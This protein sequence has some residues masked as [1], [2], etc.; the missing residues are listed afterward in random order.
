MDN[1]FIYAY[2]LFIITFA[3]IFWTSV[4]FN[5]FQIKGISMKPETVNKIKLY[6]RSLY[7]PKNYHQKKFKAVKQTDYLMKSMESLK[8]EMETQ[9]MACMHY[10]TVIKFSPLIMGPL[11]LINYSFIPY[12]ISVI[13]IVFIVFGFTILPKNYKLIEDNRQYIDQT[14][15]T[16]K[17]LFPE[18]DVR[19]VLLKDY[20]SKY[21]NTIEKQKNAIM[22][23]IKEALQNSDYDLDFQSGKDSDTENGPDNPF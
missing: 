4:M 1:I 19:S 22:D 20:I 7:I 12:V 11:L 15:Y 10:A 3:Y 5:F 18:E 23:R 6:L 21:N 9:Y 17:Q 14:I 8:G 16:L 13:S 2:Y